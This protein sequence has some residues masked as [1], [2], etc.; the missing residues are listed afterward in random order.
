MIF[1]VPEPC[2][3]AQQPRAGRAGTREPGNQL[4]D[5]PQRPA[6]VFADPVRAPAGS[7]PDG[8]EAQIGHLVAAY[9]RRGDLAGT[10][11]T[12]TVRIAL[13][14]AEPQFHG[15]LRAELRPLQARLN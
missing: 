4:F 10:P 11:R 12:A 7:Q 13:A 14:V 15:V 6:S 2:V 9:Q 3:R 5:E 1:D 8:V